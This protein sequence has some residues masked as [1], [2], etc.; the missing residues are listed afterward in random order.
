MCPT[1]QI[2]V[3]YKHDLT[4]VWPLLRSENECVTIT[5]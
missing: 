1:E 5:Y 4:V 2:R 3:P